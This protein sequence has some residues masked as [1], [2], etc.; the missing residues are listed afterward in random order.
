M[1]W[2][3]AVQCFDNFAADTSRWM[4]VFLRELLLSL[5]GRLK[6]RPLFSNRSSPEVNM[7]GYY[8]HA[9]DVWAFG[10][11]AWELYKSF[12]EGENNPQ[13]SIPYFGLENNQVNFTKVVCLVHSIGNYTSNAKI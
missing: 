6:L 2:D 5:S 3:N 11:L 4:P 9:S 10:I 13:L 1:H 12:Q 8:T 7:D